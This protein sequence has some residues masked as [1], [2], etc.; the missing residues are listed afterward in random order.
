MLYYFSGTG[1]SRY[2]CEKVAKLLNERYC[3][4]TAPLYT[5][6]SSI[7]I[8]FPVYA[9]GMP[10]IMQRFIE[11]KLPQLIGNRENLYVYI[12]MTCGDDIG[13]TDRLVAASL[14]KSGLHLSAAF[15]LQMPNTY[16]SLPGFDVDSMELSNAKVM[17]ATKAIPQIAYDIRSHSSVT[18]VVRGGMAWTKT[19]LIRPLFM[20]FLM[21]D[22]RFH[23]DSR[24]THCG[25]CSVVCPMNN[26]IMMPMNNIKHPSWQHHCEGCL[27][28][29]HACPH[30]AIEYGPFTRSKGQKASLP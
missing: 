13:Y 21:G 24:C 5:A 9:W 7:G 22:K 14:K 19:Y 28:C 17:T 15:S 3:K 8:I 16:V 12:I 18:K 4:I 11:N 23:V 10:H 1:N 26:I 20:R 2:V 29:Y 25:R 30:H 27:A 6:D